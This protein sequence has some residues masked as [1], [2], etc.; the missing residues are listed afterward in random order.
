MNCRSLKFFFSSFILLLNQLKFSVPVIA[1]TET[2]TTCDTENCFNIPGYNFVCR[3]RESGIWGWVAL[4]IA[5]DIGFYVR[6]DLNVEGIPESVFIELYQFGMIIGCIYKP[7][8]ANVGDF[9]V[10]LEKLLDTLEK[11][12]QLCY[13]AGDLNI[14]I[15][16]S[17]VHA[18]PLLTS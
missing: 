9:V 2:W 4:Y 11:Q 3:S 12:K 13:L 14:D 15:L 1:L 8:N 18:R 7:P 17:D 10:S 6:N 5:D 16:K